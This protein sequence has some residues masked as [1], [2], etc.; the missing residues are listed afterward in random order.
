MIPFFLK[1][2]SKNLE[3]CQPYLD[4]VVNLIL[5]GQVDFRF[6][7]EKKGKLPYCQEIFN[8][9]LAK[10]EPHFSSSLRERKAFENLF[11][12][13]EEAIALIDETGQI[14]KT[15]SRFNQLFD[16]EWPEGKF[17]W[18]IIR[19]S[20]FQKVY[21]SFKDRREKQEAELYLRGRP[22]L[23]K[24]LPL[25]SKVKEEDQRKEKEEVLAKESKDRENSQRFALILRDIS[26]EKNLELIKRELVA[27]ISHE[28]R[29][30][31]TTIKGYL[32]TLEEEEL[33]SE[34]RYYV[35]I[36]KTNLDRL[37][38]IV[39]DLLT[40]SELESRSTL[41]EREKV[42]LKEVANRVIEQF[43]KLAQERNLYLRLEAP[44]PLPFIE[45]DSFRLE[46]MLVNLVDNG[47]KYTD[48]GGVT[49]KLEEKEKEILVAVEDTGIGIPPEH[50]DRIFE[51]FYVV[52]RSRSRKLGGTGLGLSIVKHIV[53]LHGGHIEVKSRE[54]IGT[55]FLVFLPKT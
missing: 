15:N 9:L 6:K 47:L 29:T 28:L 52:D 17:V 24:F 10:L 45:G 34:A 38:R 46:Q 1:K 12:H 27:N 50:L 30:P 21:F 35:G 43:G 18:Q 36:I 22:F 26:P 14:L 5:E 20:D 13:M 37:E 25:I 3:A 7:V 54:G 53:L 40:L 49:I 16:F 32:E 39:S 48:K 44:S 8:L 19:S 51:R 41:I 31:L 4:Q 11:N 23:V 42:D 55:S 2:K 33:K